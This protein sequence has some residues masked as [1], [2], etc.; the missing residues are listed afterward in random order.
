MCGRY[1]IKDTD[2]LTAE[3]RKLFNIPDWVKDQ[4]APR[5]NI[6]PGQEC[7]VIKLDE[8]SDVIVPASMPW[9]I[10]PALD[11]TGKFFLV[12]IR[13]DNAVTN[14]LLKRD[15]Q[16]TRCLVPADGFYEWRRDTPKVSYP[17]EFHLKAG[18]P[19]VMAAV[20]QKAQADKPA[21]FAILT[22]GPNE[23]MAR[24]HDRMPVILE[25]DAAHRWL[26]RGSIGPDE[27]T[28]LATPHPAADMEAYPISEL[29][30]NVKNDL[31]DVLEPVMAPPPRQQQAELF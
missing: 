24:I 6:G 2:L 26:Q 28:A 10:R 12:N 19:F 7:P 16:Q 1:H 17:F 29:V 4:N 18:R 3:M 25:R 27:I 8:K 13:A 31:P 21:T 22:T 23:L 20:Y 11:N 15:V 14:R 9:G 5:Y 30:N